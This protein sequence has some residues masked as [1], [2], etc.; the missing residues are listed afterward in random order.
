MEMLEEAAWDTQG[1]GILGEGGKFALLLPFFKGCESN[2]HSTNR[3]TNM[4]VTILGFDFSFTGWSG[5]LISRM[6]FLI[7]CSK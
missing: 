2:T 1:G 6:I 5:I 7:F 3:N 4:L